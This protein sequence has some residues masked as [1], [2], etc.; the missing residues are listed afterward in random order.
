MLR[1]P[2]TTRRLVSMPMGQKLRETTHI[3]SIHGSCQSDSNGAS[4]KLDTYDAR[5][6]PR[7]IARYNTSTHSAVHL[8]Q[9]E[10]LYTEVRPDSTIRLSICANRTDHDLHDTFPNP[11]LRARFCAPRRVG[12]ALEVLDEEQYM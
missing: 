8:R 7:Q 6:S 4:K 3:C 2:T 10:I 5:A 1:I 9:W 11:L 12:R